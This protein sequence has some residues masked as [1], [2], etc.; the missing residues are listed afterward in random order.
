M[1]DPMTTVLD[2]LKTQTA[3][4]TLTTSQRIY[5]DPDLPREYKPETGEMLT[6]VIRGGI[7][8]YTSQVLDL[9]FQFRSYGPA[10]PACVAVD[11]AL[12]DIL[13]DISCGDIKMAR[14]ETAGRPLREQATGWPF[15]LSFYR[16]QFNSN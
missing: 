1:I 15:V 4:T 3:L 13:Q 11:R 6:F 10:M 8:D 9:S 2:Y 12:F 7:P 14:Q 5:A 16:I